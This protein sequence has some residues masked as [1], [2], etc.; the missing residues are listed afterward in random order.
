MKKINLK[1]YRIEPDA[2]NQAIRKI[3]STPG[4][5]ALLQESGAWLPEELNFLRMG[6]ADSNY[7]VKDSIK[8]LLLNQ[9]GIQG[10]EFH[11]RLP[12]ADKI[13][14][15][16][17]SIKLQDTEYEKI[18]QAVTSHTQWGTGDAEFSRRIFEAKDYDPNEDKPKKKKNKN[19]NKK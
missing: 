9:K 18:K 1:P 3:V 15:A 6:M 4:V 2:G 10:D 12:L 5:F 13:M 7:Q 14:N 17:D 11:D 8:R 16:G 19:K